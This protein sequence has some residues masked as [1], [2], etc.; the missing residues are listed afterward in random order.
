M[1]LVVCNQLHY[2]FSS[3]N[4]YILLIAMSRIYKIKVVVFYLSLCL[5]FKIPFYT[6]IFGKNNTFHKID[7]F[8]R[9]SIFLIRGDDFLNKQNEMNMFCLA[10]HL[11]LAASNDCQP[12]LYSQKK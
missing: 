1:L 2:F 12:Q 11:L 3:F 10:N 4:Q 8:L 7:A 9:L 5:G 6:L